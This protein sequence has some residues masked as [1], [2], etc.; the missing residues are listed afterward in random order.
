[1]N[2]ELCWL[3]LIIIKSLQPIKIYSHDTVLA[4]HNKNQ[5]GSLDPHIVA[6]TGS[7]TEI[8][9][10]IVDHRGM[11]SSFWSFHSRRS[12]TNCFE[13]LRR[14]LKIK[15]HIFVVGRIKLVKSVELP[16]VLEP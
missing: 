6:V 1:V 11:F 13:N 4:Y 2:Q 9:R 10:E 8:N 15:K 5:Y 7:S 3:P 16:E 12:R 14:K